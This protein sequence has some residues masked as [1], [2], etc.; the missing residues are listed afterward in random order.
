MNRR[1]RITRSAWG[2]LVGGIFGELIESGNFVNFVDVDASLRAGH[3]RLGVLGMWGSCTN[4]CCVCGRTVT[5]ISH[6]L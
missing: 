1:L 2:E 6:K 5:F 4:F 3:G